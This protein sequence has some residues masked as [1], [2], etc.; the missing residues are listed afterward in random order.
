MGIYPKAKMKLLDWQEMRKTE[1]ILH[2]MGL[3]VDPRCLVQ[4][5]PLAERQ[6]IEISKI[7]AQ[8]ARLIILDEPTAALPIGR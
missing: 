5:L 7:L 8:G 2:E 1:S 4:D 3:S 6:I